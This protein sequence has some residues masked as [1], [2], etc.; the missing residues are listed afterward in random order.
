MFAFIKRPVHESAQSEVYAAF[1]F[2]LF[3]MAVCAVFLEDRAHI[4]LK[5]ECLIRSMS[6][7]GEGTEDNSGS[8]LHQ[9]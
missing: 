8:Q 3:T 6:G 2:F 5:R 7:E 1:G 4:F 9:G